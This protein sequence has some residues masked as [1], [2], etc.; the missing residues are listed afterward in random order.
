MNHAVQRVPNLWADARGAT[1]V[2]FA[3]VAPILV[4]M[5]MFLFD[6]GYYLYARAILGGEVQAAG[7]ASALETATDTN[8]VLLDTSVEN[9]VK[10]L[11]GV[12]PSR[13]ID[14]HSNPTAGAQS[15]AEAFFRF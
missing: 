13:S 7:R 14:C 11:V 9:A 15:R 4:V 2:E 1:I 6:T 12:A 8:R 3:I 10:R 5:L